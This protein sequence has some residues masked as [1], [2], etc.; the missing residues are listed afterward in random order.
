M[1][2][3]EKL[4]SEYDGKLY[5]FSKNKEIGEKFL[6]DAEKE[7]Y[8]FG[9]DKPTDR[10]WSDLIAVEKDKTIS[11]V[12]ALG[13]MARSAGSVIEIDYDKYAQNKE[14]FRIVRESYK[15]KYID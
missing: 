13:R 8:L 4:R 5:V 11:Y 15:N 10:E 12:G 9:K 6:R 7:G 1:R 2:S 14:N 3:I